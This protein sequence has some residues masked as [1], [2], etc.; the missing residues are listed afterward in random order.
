MIEIQNLTKYYGDFKA[1]DNISLTINDGEIVGFIGSNGAGKSTTIKMMTGIIHPDEGDVLLNGFSIKHPK[2]NLLAKKQFGF[3]PDT[4]DMF[5][6]LTGIQYL[7]FICDIY[8]VPKDVRAEKISK[9]AD[10]FHIKNSLNDRILNYSHGMRQKINVVAVLLYEPSI[11]ILDEPMVGLDPEAADLL[12]RKMKEHAAK[13]NI[14]FMSTHVISMAEALCDKVIVIKH[15]K[16]LFY[17]TIE[18]L[19]ANKDESM[20]KILLEL[21][22][23]EG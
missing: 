20:E 21:I 9:L 2:I 19:K 16:V 13:G 7:N 17:G 22:E 14:V 1:V 8:N 6:R 23:K 5:L 15:G 12:K 11:W 10:E 18:E 4:P 3:V